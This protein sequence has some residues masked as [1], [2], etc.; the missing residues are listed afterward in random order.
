MT[1][2]K[3]HLERCIIRWSIFDYDVVHR[4][5]VKHQSAYSLYCLEASG[6]DNTLMDDIPFL[7]MIRD[8][9]HGH[10]CY[11]FDAM[12]LPIAFPEVLVT[13]S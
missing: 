7:V 3:G 13:T 9:A 12:K 2:A 6:A 1:E 5:G 10:A 11:D 8:G 4:R